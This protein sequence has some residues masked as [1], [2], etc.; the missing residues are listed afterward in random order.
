MT[1]ADLLDFMRQHILAVEASVSPTGAPQAAVIGFAVSDA[2]EI[3]FDT[4]AASRKVANLRHNPTV[5]FAI[6]GT[7][8]GDDRSVQYQGIADEPVGPELQRLKELY[9]EVLPDGGQRETWPDITYIR[10]RPDWIRYV[11]FNPRSSR[12]RRVRSDA[13]RR[14]GVT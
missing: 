3:V 14:F 1:T 11:D 6:G 13:I 4:N 12:N 8:R 7:T 10:V 5:A 9:F 2:L